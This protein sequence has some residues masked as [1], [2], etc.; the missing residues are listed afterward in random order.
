MRAR[1]W[2]S[3]LALCAS[4]SLSAGSLFAYLPAAAPVYAQSYSETP[5]LQASNMTIAN[6]AGAADVSSHLDTLKSLGQGTIQL[7][8]RSTDSQA[9]SAMLSM[10]STAAGQNNTYAV[11]YINPSA[12]TVGVEVRDTAG[13]NYNQVS[14][15][16]AGIKDDKWHTLTYCFGKTTFSI[17]VDGEKKTEQEKSG[18]FDKLTSPDTLLIGMQKR[19]SSNGQWQF[20]G[21]I[22]SL[23]VYDHVLSIGEISEY[24]SATDFDPRIPDDPEDAV[25]TDEK[26]YYNNYDNSRAYRIPSLLTTKQGTVIAA[27]DQRHSGS[28]DCG[29]IDTVIRRSTDGGDT[30]GPVQTLIDLPSGSNGMHALTIDP[31]MVQDRETGRIFLLVDMFPESNALLSTNLQSALSGYKE[32]DGEKY[33]VLRDYENSNAAESSI[34]WTTEYTVRENGV[35]WNESTNQPTEYTVDNLANGTIYKTENG[36]R[37]EAG[38]IYV[39]TGANAG[40]LKAIRTAHLWMIHSDDEGQTWSDPVD[41]NKTVKEDWMLFMG[42]GPGVGCQ[43]DNGRLLFPYYATNANVGASQSAGVI[44]SDDHGQTWQRGET[45]CDALYAGG[46]QN[47][48]GGAMMTESQV[49]SVIDKDGQEILKLFC[50]NTGDTN[51]R[52]FTS[53]DGGATWSADYQLDTALREPYCQLTVVPYP[54]EVEGYEGKQMFLFANPDSSNRSSG[55]L[56]MGYYEPETDKFVWIQKRGITS[57]D[58]A[59][60]CLSVLGEDKI[61]LLWEGDNL[62]INFSRFNQAWLFADKTPILREAPKALKAARTAEGEV[63]VTFDQ[64]LI[65]MGAPVLNVQC[66]DTELCL[67]Y[68]QGSGSCELVFD[69]SA[70][71]GSIEVISLDL[72]DGASAENNEGTAFEAAALSGLAV[73]GDG[74]ETIHNLSVVPGYASSMLSFDS[75]PGTTYQIL[76]SSKKSYGYTVAGEVTADGQRCTFQD[77]VG[78]GKKYYYRVAAN[79]QQDMSATVIAAASTGMDALKQNAELYRN[80]SRTEFDGSTVVDLSEYASVL[81][82]MDEGSLII[83]FYTDE[84]K[85]Q[86]LFNASS[87]SETGGMNNNTRM[88]SI[89]TNPT[90]LRADLAHTR[91]NTNAVG[92]GQWHTLMVSCANKGKTFR[93][94]LD[95]QEDHSWTA[96]SLSGFL[97]TV[98]SLERVTVGG[99]LAGDSEEV[100][101]GFTGTIQYVC[102][103]SEVIDDASAAI[104]TAEVPAAKTLEIASVEAGYASNR[105]TLADGAAADI[106]R[107]ESEFGTYEKAGST[108]NGIF[109]DAVE[110]GT[111]Y[112]YKAI[113]EDGEIESDPIQAD[114][115]VSRQAF[116]ASANVFED[117]SETVFDGSTMVSI[118]EQASAISSLTA[119]TIVVRFKTTE[120]D[121]ASVL[122]MGKKAG[123]SVSMTSASNKGSVSITPDRGQARP[124]FDFTH[125]RASVQQDAAD[126]AWHT[127][128]ITQDVSSASSTFR[129]TL[130][131]KEYGNYTGANNTGFFSKVAGM[132]SLSIGGFV[133]GSADTVSNGF[134]GEIGYVLV[135][136]EILDT[137]SAERLSLEEN[138]EAADKT[139]LQMS[140]AYALA[141]EKPQHIHALAWQNFE[142]A[143]SHAQTVLDDESASQKQT[144]EAWKALC[145]AIHMLS[146][147]ADKSGLADLIEQA[148]AIDLSQYED[149]EAKAAFEAALE[150]ALAVLNNETALDPSIE[151]AFASLSEAMISLTPKAEAVDTALLAWLYGQVKDTDLN[152]YANVQEELDAF[153]A[154]LKKAQAVLADP[155]SQQQADDALMELHTAWMQLRLKP[156][157]ELLRQLQQALAHAKALDLANASSK[158]AKLIASWID[159]TEKALDS[160][161]I[162]AKTTQDLVDEYA[163]LK[164]AMEK[165]KPAETNTSQ[166]VSKPGKP[167]ASVSTG[168]AETGLWTVGTMLSALGALVL[169]RKNKK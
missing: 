33:F 149:D 70:A 103:T 127:F 144:D 72:P 156:S 143:L 136:D 95:G 10:S 46:T 132:D 48:T 51:V 110:A 165:L 161:H 131:G 12:D 45:V 11:A 125:T 90:S 159:R 96:A 123:E 130:D 82:N 32:V 109:R 41:M 122:L 6:G 118:D 47:M 147:T 14:V 139:L 94:V 24:H 55:A 31:S 73:S 37:Q 107:S 137:A 75:K 135:T 17:Y 91:A 100:L 99:R 71:A 28:S 151:E 86:A 140:V 108:T 1:K 129:M 27:I 163:S 25:R 60:S 119:G 29:N 30:W 4:L 85:M 15:K 133:N 58:Y 79:S 167:S 134:K 57:T 106:Y 23:Q 22:E 98:A 104:L 164:P 3:R 168:L 36:T 112:F 155:K 88:A 34:A 87:A 78:L 19:A 160:G 124:R 138:M 84:A 35:V 154:A 101:D 44:Y 121:S 68:T 20:T 158:E 148:Q 50:R 52:I 2:K 142:Q 146:F 166:S 63:V 120:A 89:M 153:A 114:A 13:G 69:G 145:K 117:V 128:V 53:R 40:A 61:G 141:I 39:Y 76:R 77:S 21:E 26:L 92:F 67:P 83:Q 65:V 97:S 8:Y 18:F 9:L 157:E 59:Y 49:V 105:I 74:E 7:R 66:G 102:V 42:T 38:N 56:Q 162:D 62:D 169:K 115:P 80:L 150:A 93:L 43:M 116:K 152:L 81:Q 64:P 54:Y 16:N 126:G 5:L 111:R 113:S